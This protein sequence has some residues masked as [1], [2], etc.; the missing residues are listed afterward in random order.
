MTAIRRLRIGITIGLHDAGETLWNNGTKQNAMFLAEA[1]KHCANVAAVTLVNTTPSVPTRQ[2]RMLDI[3][4]RIPTP[5]R[6]CD[7]Q[8]CGNSLTSSIARC[9][10]YGMG[11]PD[12]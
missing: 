8:K 6:V 5:L 10:G 12:N 2:C 4:L 1:L 9:W 7:D 3:P 11:M